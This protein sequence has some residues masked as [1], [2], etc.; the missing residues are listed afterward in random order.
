[1][2]RDIDGNLQKIAD[3]WIDR[4]K[5]NDWRIT[6]EDNVNPMDMPGE[7]ESRGYVAYAE[8]VKEASIYL[9]DP[10]CMPQGNIF[11]YDKER[12]LVHELLHIKL[13]LL[14]SEDN[15]TLQDR[16]V[17]QIID[18]LSYAFVDA[19]RMANEKEKEDCDICPDFDPPD[20]NRY[21][22]FNLM[23]WKDER[24]NEHCLR[25]NGNRVERKSGYRT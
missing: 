25:L 18:E 12:T 16:I 2:I 21:T 6:I 1:M 3:E 19:K 8:S 15:N 9:L 14:Q 4:L 10:L 23:G 22:S 11:G 24:G 5:L 13:S 17:H 7:C 20:N